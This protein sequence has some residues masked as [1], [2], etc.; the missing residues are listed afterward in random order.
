M[1]RIRMIRV[2]L[3]IRW[4]LVIL[5]IVLLVILLIVLRIVLLIVLLRVL[6]RWRLSV[7]QRRRLEAVLEGRLLL[8][9]VLRVVLL[10]LRVVLPVLR[11]HVPNMSVRL[12]VPRGRRIAPRAQL[13]GLG[14]LDDAHGPVSYTHLTL[15]TIA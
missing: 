7:L 6:G 4:M 2:L 1:L 11:G 14:Q 8:C 9:G 5:L 15:P 13:G 12:I 10:L 3:R